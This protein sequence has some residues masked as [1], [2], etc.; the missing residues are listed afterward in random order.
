[1]KTIGN[2]QVIRIKLMVTGLMLSIFFS[3]DNSS[4]AQITHHVTNETKR[5][6]KLAILLDTS[7]SMDGLIEQAKSQLWSIVNEL[8]RAECDNTKPELKIAL[9]E[10][11]NDNLPSDEGYIRMVTPLTTDLDQI[12]DDLFSLR[13]RGGQEFCGQVISTALN[14]LSWSAT[15]KDY[16]VMFIAGN[17]PFTQG[18]I[19]YQKA[20]GEAARKGVVVNTIYCGDFNEGI[21]TSWKSGADITGGNY[22]SI[23]HNRK[24]VFIETPF[25]RQIS[26]LNDRLNN[27]YIYYGVH[28]Q[29]KKMM[30][31]RQDKNAEAYGTANA[32]NRA[33]SKSS[34]V[35]KNEAWDLVDASEET[36]FDVRRIE[37]EQLPAEMQKMND[38]EKA[39]YIEKKKAE[40]DAVKEEINALSRKRNEYLAARQ[41]ESDDEGMLDKAIVSSI[42][43]QAN[44]KN[45]Q[46][47]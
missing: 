34:H 20:C 40:R 36:D 35:Y 15:G 28:G 33:V 46:F 8:A 32:V 21:Q 38:T 41:K 45:F 5:S 43:K 37:D 29:E 39:K 22:F 19:S 11:G 26:E 47:K 7:N 17:E 2:N 44:T 9:Y 13:T 27:T 42:K 4:N 31:S 14:E 18:T 3:C 12:S 16:Q 6:I 23:D 25:D 1:M 10:Y 24:T 30:Q